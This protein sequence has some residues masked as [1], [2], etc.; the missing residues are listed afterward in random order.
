MPFFTKK[1]NLKEGLAEYFSYVEAHCL[2]SK[3][4][5]QKYREVAVHLYAV[6]GDINLLKLAESDVIKLKQNLNARDLSPSRKNHY[7]VVLKAVLRHYQ[8]R[9]HKVYSPAL[10]QKYPVPTK[11]VEHLSKEELI[12]VIQ[13]VDSDSTSQLR[14]RAAILSLIST[15]C[16]VSELLSLNRNDIDFS[17]GIV[18]VRTK[19][20][21]AHQLIFNEESLEAIKNYWLRRT[22]NCEAVFATFNTSIPR[23]WQVND[24]ERSLRNLG[25]RMKLRLSLRPH[26]L[27]KSAAT[28]MYREGVPV[29]VIQNFLNHSSPQ[30]T[31]RYY[32]GNLGFE[33]V[34]KNHARVLNFRSNNQ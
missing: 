12:A 20:D 34:K 6:L 26:L 27:R 23:R 19:G 18:S 4:S 13:A 32:L 3:N 33:E 29:G 24:L 21:K 11:E 14:L 7:L 22:D 25:K 1:I 8:E 16:R 2:L 30:V 17:T 15:G 10:I 9:G 28:L 31:A 5:I